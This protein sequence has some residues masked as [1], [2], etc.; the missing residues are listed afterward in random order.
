MHSGDN[1]L[2]GGAD[3][4]DLP[5]LLF[6]ALV[7][8]GA[9]LAL[10]L[11]GT[12]AGLSG[13]TSSVLTGLLVATALDLRPRIAT[14]SAALLTALAVT[15]NTQLLSLGSVKRPINILQLMV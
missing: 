5:A 10:A 12:E 7:G 13:S 1:G 3:D 2:G 14:S 15:H 8:P 6:R 11:A 4:Q 9:G